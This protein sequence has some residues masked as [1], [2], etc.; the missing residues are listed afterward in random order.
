MR[1]QFTVACGASST[2][3]ATTSTATTGL[4]ARARAERA[5]R[6]PGPRR[7]RRSSSKGGRDRAR[8]RLRAARGPRQRHRPHRNRHARAAVDHR[9]HLE[10][11]RRRGRAPPVPRPVRHRPAVLLPGRRHDRGHLPLRAHA[12]CADRALVRQSD[13]TFSVGEPREPLART[14]DRGP[15]DDPARYPRWCTARRACAVRD[16][17]YAELLDVPVRIGE[18]TLS[19]QPRRGRSPRRS[20][21][22]GA[23]SGSASRRWGSSRSTRS[24]R[25]SSAW[26][27]CCPYTARPGYRTGDRIY[28][29]GMLVADT[30]DLVIPRWAFF[31]RAVVDAGDLPLTASRE[32]LQESA[33]LQFVRSRSVSDCSPS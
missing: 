20:S 12:R 23:R 25:A 28:S 14:R 7:A 17:S 33:E 31:C 10:A 2:S 22:P 30:D 18:A 5:R 15:P 29:K 26:R 13:G 27:S 1:E 3:S 11:V 9:Q 32:G 24:P 4:P 6:H 19:Q 8:P 21:W 16:A